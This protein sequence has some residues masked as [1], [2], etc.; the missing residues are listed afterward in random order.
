MRVIDGVK[1]HHHPNGGGLVA[2]TAFVDETVFV[3]ED[4]VVSGRATARDFT[5]IYGCS[6]IADDAFVFNALVVDSVICGDARVSGPEPFEIPDGME[7]LDYSP[8]IACSYIGG[9]AQIY[10]ENR[11]CFERIEFDEIRQTLL[12]SP[13]K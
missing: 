10:G 8:R 12:H 3:D 7:L 1:Y 11:I 6:E 5:V 2:E 13:P 4:A 9:S